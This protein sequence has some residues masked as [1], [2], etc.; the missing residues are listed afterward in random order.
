MN[1]QSQTNSSGFIRMRM[2]QEGGAVCC[3]E[4]ARSSAITERHAQHSVSVEML[5]AVV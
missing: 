1:K 3:H 5:S 4:Q 2:R